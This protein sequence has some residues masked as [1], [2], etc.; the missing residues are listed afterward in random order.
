MKVAHPTVSVA[1]KALVVEGYI[2]VMEKLEGGM[3]AGDCD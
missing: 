3:Y 1:L 2:F